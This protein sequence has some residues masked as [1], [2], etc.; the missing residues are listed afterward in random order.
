MEY[1]K[2]T[3]T[4]SKYLTK[5]NFLGMET[6]E[7]QENYKTEIMEKEGRFISDEKQFN[8]FKKEFRNNIHFSIFVKEVFVENLDLVIAYIII[9]ECLLLFYQDYDN[10]G[11]MQQDGFRYEFN[12]LAKPT[13][14]AFLSSYLTGISVISQPQE[15]G[16][17][18]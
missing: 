2:Q 8:R 17:E 15:K 1:L 13:S 16:K 3:Q 9:Q 11:S 6:Q 7:L 4:Q 5:F 12:G 10:Q 14:I 18:A